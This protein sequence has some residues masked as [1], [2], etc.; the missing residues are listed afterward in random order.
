[1]ATFYTQRKNS[2]A[3]DT[4]NSAAASLKAG[5]LDLCWDASK[6][7]FYDFNITAN[8]RNPIFTVATFYPLWNGII[9]AELTN[10]TEAAFGYFSALNMVLNRYNGTFPVTFHESGQQ[11]CVSVYFIRTRARI[12]TKINR[13]APNAWPPHQHIVLEALKALPSNVTSGALP[14]PASNQ[15]TF[16]LIP[17]GQL[18]VL[19]SGLPA[20]LVIGSGNATTTGP[21]ADIN[22]LNGTVFN[23]GNATKG[24]DWSKTLQRELANRYFASALCSW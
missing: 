23:G 15:S 3:A 2:S 1:M 24:E 8:A 12:T 22:T 16:D 6:L 13:D 20:Q 4:H 7:A 11:W 10:S 14:T 21:Q 5:I 18:D 17:S 9:P 19:E